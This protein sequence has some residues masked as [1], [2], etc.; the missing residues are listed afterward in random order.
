MR[1]V[2]EVLGQQQ[3][4]QTQRLLRNAY[5]LLAIILTVSAIAAGFSMQLV[6]SPGIALVLSLASLGLIFVVNRT[7]DSAAGLAWALVFAVCSGGSIGPLLNYYANLPAGSD[8]IMQALAGTALIF[9]VLSA[10]AMN[11]SRD[12]SALRSMLVVGLVVTLIAVVANLFLQIPALQ[13]TISAV[14][15]LLMSGFI[16]YD[17]SQMVHGGETNYIRAAVSMYINVFNLFVSLLRLIG[18]F[19][20]DD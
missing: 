19:S 17:T 11:A 3:Q 18:F 12:F 8:I 10:I 9:F 16:L 7:A 14:L 2:Q 1:T 4:L 6:T 20:S 15:V 5:S 13:L